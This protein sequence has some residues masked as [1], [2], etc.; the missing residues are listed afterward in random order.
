MLYHFINDIEICYECAWRYLSTY[1]LQVQHSCACGII[2][3]GECTKA[4]VN[5]VTWT[6]IPDFTLLFV[7]VQGSESAG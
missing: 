2:V 7:T 5:Y 4:R 3:Q 1:A 6:N